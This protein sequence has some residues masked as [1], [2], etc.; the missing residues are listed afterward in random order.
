MSNGKTR[1]KKTRTTA[2][3]TRIGNMTA[4][5]K[6]K[7]R[8]D[9]NGWPDWAPHECFVCGKRVLVKQARELRYSVKLGIGKVRHLDPADCMASEHSA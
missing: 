9:G 8:I 7:P 3:E 1:K 6:T 5:K 2:P 4:P